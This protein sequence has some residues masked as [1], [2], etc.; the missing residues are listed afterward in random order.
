[1]NKNRRKSLKILGLS[2]GVTLCPVFALSRETPELFQW[3]GYALGA[4]TEIQIYANERNDAQAAVELV[5]ELIA[6]LEGIFSL[7]DPGSEIVELNKAGKLE[8]ASAEIIELLEISKSFSRGTN[9]AFDITVQPLWELYDRFRSDGDEVAFDRDLKKIIPLIGADKINIDGNRVSFAKQN[10]A[11]SFNGIA[12]GYITDK[13]CALLKENG[14]THTLIDVGEYCAGGPQWGGDPWRIG[15]L[16]PFNQISVADIM[17]LSSGGLATSGGYG[18]VFADDGSKHH[19]FNP[20]T[21]LS[22]NQYA[23]VTVT[24]E[25]ATT[26]DALSTAFSNMPPN[27]I[28]VFVKDHGKLEARLTHF[29]GRVTKIIS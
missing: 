27:S 9:G 6:K 8:N 13:A 21:G 1:M 29:D 26:A 12:Q 20:V 17:E 3:E 2:A 11:I 16:D 19:L 14:F 18:T 28:A 24:A 22:A 23:S 10:M 15:L 25:G 4:D 5:K 7:Y